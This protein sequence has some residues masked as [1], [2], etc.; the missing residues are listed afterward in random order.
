MIFLT[1]KAYSLKVIEAIEKNKIST[2]RQLNLYKLQLSKEF[3]LKA[4]PA[5][6]D[7][8]SFAKRPSRKLI[9]LLSIKPVRTLSGIAVVA[10][11]VK[12]HSCP[13][14]C[15]YCPNGI[16]VETPKSYTG[17]EPAAMRALMFNFDPY[18]QVKNRIQQLKTTGH[19]TEKIE[20]IIMGGTFPSTS[21]HYQKWFVKR[22]LDA[23]AEKKSRNLLQAKK[24]AE[25]S[26]NRAIGITFET[27]PDFCGKK[28]INRMLFLGGTRVELGVQAVSDSIYRKIHRGHLVKDVIEATQLL[29]DSAFKVGYHLMP[30]LYGLTPKEDLRLFERV[31]SEQQFRPDMLKIY[32]TLVIEGTGLYKLWKSGHYKPY[33]T[34]EAAEFIASVKRFVP[35]WVRIMRVQRDIPSGFIAAGVTKSNLRQLV[36]KKL[37]ERGIRCRCIRCREAGLK[38]KKE[39]IKARIADAKILKEEYEASNGPEVFISAED[40]KTDSLFGFCRL[41][42][43]SQPF[44][45]EIS[46]KTALIRELHV[47]GKELCLGKREKEA[48]QHRGLGKKLLGEAERIAFEQFDKEKMVVIAGLGVREYYRKNFSYKDDGPYLSRK[49]P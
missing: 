48:I 30:G 42:I 22:C 21:P 40:K 28:E 5:N 32:P 18:S 41:R 9:D 33:S 6:P 1:L 44:R 10:V 15:I 16:E 31:F 49:I 37:K 7:M 47:Y 43:P 27:R 17:K 39:K 8:L 23:I 38:A 45:K 36:E 2:K 34:E 29:K 20:L 35:K 25:K 13:G 24:H 26:K 11:M 46:E 14:R 12:P 19:K 4:M 3:G